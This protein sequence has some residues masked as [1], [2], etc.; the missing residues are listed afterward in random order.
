MNVCR[1]S[2]A[3]MSFRLDMCRSAAMAGHGAE[4]P[5]QDEDLKAL[6]YPKT[7]IIYRQLTFN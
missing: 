7:D 3:C 6:L 1:M 2:S 5:L 4:T